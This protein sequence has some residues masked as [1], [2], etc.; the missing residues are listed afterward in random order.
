MLPFQVFLKNSFI[1]KSVERLP[2]I[3]WN[4]KHSSMLLTSYKIHTGEEIVLELLA[5]KISESFLF[6]QSKKT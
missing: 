3:I 2:F 6:E 4:K 1:R 5:L